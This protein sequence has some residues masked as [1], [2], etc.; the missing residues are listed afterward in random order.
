MILTS[1]SS[2]FPG[3]PD[4]ADSICPFSMCELGLTESRWCIQLSKVGPLESDVGI[5]QLCHF[6]WWWYW[7]I[8]VPIV[9]PWAANLELELRSW[10]LQIFCSFYYSLILLQRV[11]HRNSRISI[12][13]S[14][15]KQ[16]PTSTCSCFPNSSCKQKTSKHVMSLLGQIKW[17]HSGIFLNHILV[18]IF[19]YFP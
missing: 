4:E 8:L 17:L 3:M 15:F 13:T 19:W 11:W 18:C 9:Q 10:Q 14:A 6:P 2:R 12:C 1:A 5:A 7:F 16:D